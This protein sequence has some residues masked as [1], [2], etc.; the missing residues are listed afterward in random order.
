[1]KKFISFFCAIVFSLILVGGASGTENTKTTTII[2]KFPIINISP[3]D[4]EEAVLSQVTRII[5][6]KA[7]M[8]IF[9]GLSVTDTKRFWSD[10]QV[11]KYKKIKKIDLWLNSPGGS[12]FTGLAL[13]DEIQAAQDEGFTITAYASG[14]IASAAV[15]IYAVCKPRYAKPS[16]IFMVHES[17]LWKWPGRE[18]HSDI[19]SQ[20]KLMDLLQRTYLNILVNNSNLSF[21]EWRLLEAKTSWFS[22]EK[23]LLIGLVDEV[24]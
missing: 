5:G 16:T 4:N 14:I 22:V 10:I 18:T 7:I 17:A 20:G 2:E 12:A 11:L 8:T 9:S 6:D 13:A 3:K 21:D 24:R 19:I 23:A 15:P 1:M